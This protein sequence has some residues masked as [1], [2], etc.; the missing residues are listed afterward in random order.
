M[1]LFLNKHSSPIEYR[2]LYLFLSSFVQTLNF[3][4]NNKNIFIK[5]VE[6][7]Y[8]SIELI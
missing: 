2:V 8:I 1:F 6:D 4:N 7:D 3:N 5:K